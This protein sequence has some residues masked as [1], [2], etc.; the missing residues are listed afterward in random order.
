MHSKR[1]DNY[2]PVGTKTVEVA[3]TPIEVVGH[4]FVSTQA[5]KAVCCYRCAQVSQR[6]VCFENLLG[7]LS[8]EELRKLQERYICHYMLEIV[9]FR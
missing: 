3:K 1:R 6:V 2:N 5:R 7:N 9:Y 4:N 8:T